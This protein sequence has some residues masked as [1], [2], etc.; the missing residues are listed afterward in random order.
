M[1]NEWKKRCTL[2]KMKTGLRRGERRA[3]RKRDRQTKIKIKEEKGTEGRK[4]LTWVYQVEEGAHEKAHM[5][6]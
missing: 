4:L 6:G 5:Q 2:G 3:G 1:K